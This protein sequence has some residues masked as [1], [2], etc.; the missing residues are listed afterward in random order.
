MKSFLFLAAAFLFVNFLSAQNTPNPY[1][2]TITVSGSAEMNVVPDEIYVQ[3]DLSEYK[4]RSDPKVDLET[5][6]TGFLQKCRSI[7]LA[8]SLITI[9]S[10]QGNNFNYWYWR[11]SRKNPD[12]LANISYQIKFSDSKKLDALVDILDDEA[13]TNFRIVSVNHSRITE[14]RRKL[15][16]EAIKAAKEKAIYL[17]EAIQEKLGNAITVTEPKEINYSDASQI[18]QIRIRGANSVY[19]NGLFKEQGDKFTGS[20]VNFKSFKLRFELDV[21]FAMQ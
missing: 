13:T 6:K 20:D 10:Y 3:I 11:K 2:K 16:I 4:K 12:L 18:D 8:D 1:S 9:A 19:S 14:F 15:K 5:I 17:T 7:G 21:I